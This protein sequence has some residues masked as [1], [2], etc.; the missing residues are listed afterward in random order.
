VIGAL[1]GTALGLGLGSALAAA[2]TRSQQLAVVIP[3]AQ[4]AFYIAA[5]GIAGLVAA[6]APARRAAWTTMIAQSP[7]TARPPKP[8]VD[9]NGSSLAPQEAVAETLRQ[10]RH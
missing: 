3:A 7:P 6:I 10:A 8:L 2:F 9:P 1:L 5:A 4:I